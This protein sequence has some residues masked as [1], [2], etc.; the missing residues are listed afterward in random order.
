M[1]KMYECFYKIY[2]KNSFLC[3]SFNLACPY[4][5]NEIFGLL[6]IATGNC[7]EIVSYLESHFSM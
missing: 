2:C 5:A 3:L 7:S 4:N 1:L 6:L